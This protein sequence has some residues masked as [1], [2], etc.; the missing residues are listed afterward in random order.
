MKLVGWVVRVRELAKR[1]GR[2]LS[3]VDKRR[4][5]PGLSKVTNIIGDVSGKSCFLD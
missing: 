5:K 2:P 4:D 3:I 1:L